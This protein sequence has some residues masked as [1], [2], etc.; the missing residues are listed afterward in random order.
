MNHKAHRM[1][2]YLKGIMLNGM[3]PFLVMDNWKS[4]KTVKYCFRS[5]RL[6]GYCSAWLGSSEN[7]F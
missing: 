1:I 2:G 5:H 6:A 3:V 4:E 7:Q